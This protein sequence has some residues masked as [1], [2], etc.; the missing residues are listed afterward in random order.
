M[1]GLLFVLTARAQG[2]PVPPS[3]ELL[4][5][6]ELVYNVSYAFIDLGQIR[7]QTVSRVDADGRACYFSKAFIDSYQNI[8]LVDLHAVFESIMD[9]EVY[10]RRFMGKVKQ[11]NLWD[12]SRYKF[13]YD[14]NRVLIDMGQQDTVVAKR[15]TTEVRSVY[16]DGLSLY[17]YARRHLYEGKNVSVPTLVKEKNVSTTINFTNRRTTTEIDAVDYPVD[18]IEFDGM[19]DFVGIFGLTGEFEGWFSNDDARVPIFARMKVIIGS[20]HVELME[21]KRPGW[22]PP[23]AE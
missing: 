13:E 4:V 7:I 19:L 15:E 1:L 16:Q 11:D 6:E 10:S 17:F 20:V 9:P 3:N 2:V 23:R 22:A 21:W 18:V 14:R 8:P 12:F 5:G